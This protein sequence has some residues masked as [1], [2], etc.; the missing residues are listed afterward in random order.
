MEAYA[1]LSDGPDDAEQSLPPPEDRMWSD[2]EDRKWADEFKRRRA[3]RCAACGSD[4]IKQ[5]LRGK[6]YMAY[7]EWHE[8]K[9]KCL[10]WHTLV[11]SGCVQE[12]G[13]SCVDCGKAREVPSL[14]AGLEVAA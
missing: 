1:P 2:D 9:S 8:W 13:E 12:G 4:K 5:H 14:F 11:L 10:G 3:T 7:V 6:P